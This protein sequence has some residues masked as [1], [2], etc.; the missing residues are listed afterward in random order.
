MEEI[1]PPIKSWQI[2]AILKEA[3]QWELEGPL[4][5]GPTT[6]LKILGKLMG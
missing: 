3:A 6:S 2:R 5:T 1:L 4:I